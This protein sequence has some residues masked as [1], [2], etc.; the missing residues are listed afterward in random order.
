MTT[1][2]VGE[3]EDAHEGVVTLVV[4]VVELVVDALEREATRRMES[5]NLSDDEIERLGRQLAATEAELDRLKEEEGVDEGVDD[6][7]GQLDGLVS[8]AIERLEDDSATG[9]GPGY[10][11]LGGEDG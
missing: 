5:G 3:G 7:R 2:D 9:G 6:L 1:I 4:T 11:V 8:D 10:T